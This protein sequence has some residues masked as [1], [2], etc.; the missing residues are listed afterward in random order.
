MSKNVTGVIAKDYFRRSHLRLLPSTDKT[1]YR[2]N[3]KTPTA[4]FQVAAEE[5]RKEGGLLNATETHA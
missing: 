3:R 4:G 1:S 5:S 2:P